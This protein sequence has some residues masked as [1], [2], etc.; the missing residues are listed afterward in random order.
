VRVSFAL[1]LLVTGSRTGR[2]CVQ[3]RH[4]ALGRHGAI[5]PRGRCRITPGGYS[6]PRQSQLSRRAN[7]RCSTKAVAQTIGDVLQHAKKIG[8]GMAGVS[9]VG[10]E[11]PVRDAHL[12]GPCIS[13]GRLRTSTDPATRRLDLSWP[14]CDGHMPPMRLPQLQ[15]GSRTDDTVPN[16]PMIIRRFESPTHEDGR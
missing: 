12:N 13:I 10:L 14:L 7:D 1:F 8:A 2:A 9:T 15:L 5:A 3:H 6:F 11:C 16:D 4:G